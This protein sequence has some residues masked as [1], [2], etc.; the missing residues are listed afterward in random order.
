MCVR[1]TESLDLSSAGL[2]PFNIISEIKSSKKFLK[3]YQFTTFINVTL[4]SSPGFPGDPGGP[5]GPMG[6]C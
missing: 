6:P 5:R 4:T 1:M 3:K 2:L